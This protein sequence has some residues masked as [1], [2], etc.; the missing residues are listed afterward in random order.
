[1]AET[2]FPRKAKLFLSLLLIVAAF[3][4]YWGWG[5]MYGTWDIFA[6]ESMGVYAI[7][8]TLFAFGL[9]GLLLTWK[10]K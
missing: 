9:L 5:L 8:V 10:Q 4:M 1:M 2:A 7:V 3:A 6:R